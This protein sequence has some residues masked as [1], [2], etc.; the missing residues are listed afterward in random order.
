[1]A[2]MLQRIERIE[3]ARAQAVERLRQRPRIEGVARGAR[4]ACLYNIADPQG[5]PS[6]RNL[7]AV[8]VAALLDA[9]AA[10]AG[11]AMSS[12]AAPPFMRVVNTSTTAPPTGPTPAAVRAQL[13]RQA[14]QRDSDDFHRLT[15]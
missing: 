2:S 13:D 10:R 6:P 11:V 7:R 5:L 9:A 12:A 15:H 3:Q 1:M 8:R 4:M 14:Q